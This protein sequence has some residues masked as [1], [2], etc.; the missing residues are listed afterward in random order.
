MPNG[1]VAFPLMPDRKESGWIGLIYR[2]PTDTSKAR[3]AVWR[4]LKRLGALYLQQAACILP[5]KENVRDEVLQIRKKIGEYGGSSTWFEIDSLP[6]GQDDE[7]IEQFRELARRE[8]AEI[9]EECET[10]FA[11]E[12]EF[13]HFRENYTFEEAEEIRQDLEK[14]KRWLGKVED[15]DWF[16]APGHDEALAKIAWCEELLDGFEAEVYRRTEGV[17]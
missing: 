12:V 7:I 2:V 11:K 9:I 1:L 6:D 4:D 16:G 13:E 15:R 10:K 3:V 8:Y 5:R 17:D 14:V